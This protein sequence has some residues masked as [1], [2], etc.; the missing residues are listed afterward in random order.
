MK[1]YG[2]EVVNFIPGS[3]VMSTNITARQDQYASEML[4]A[5]TDDQLNFYEDY[6]HRYNEYLTHISGLKPVQVIDDGKLF[7]EFRNAILD[8][9]PKATYKC[10]PLRCAFRWR[11]I[12]DR[13]FHPI[14]FFSFSDIQ[15]I[16][17]SASSVRYF[18]EI[19]LSCNS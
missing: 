3:L 4:Q 16:T 6:F 11:K 1:K 10:E 8:C 18:C 17:R 14:F 19:G 2:V 13:K 15:F 12:L 7:M 5:F 9:W